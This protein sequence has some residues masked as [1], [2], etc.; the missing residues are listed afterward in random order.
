[1]TDALVTDSTVLDSHGF[2]LQPFSRVITMPSV[3]ASNVGHPR[4]NGDSV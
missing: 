4:E 2:Q 3:I 1:M